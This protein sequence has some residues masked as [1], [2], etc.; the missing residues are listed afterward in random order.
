MPDLRLAVPFT[1]IPML[2][3]EL[4]DQVGGSIARLPMTW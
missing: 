3:T 1:E 2:G 4:G